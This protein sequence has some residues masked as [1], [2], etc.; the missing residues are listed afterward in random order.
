MQAAISR[1]MAHKAPLR[2]PRE[3]RQV[4]LR[5]SG[6]KF[7]FAARRRHRPGRVGLHAVSGAPDTSAGPVTGG[8][9]LPRACSEGSTRDD[10]QTYRT[11][12]AESL[13][14]ARSGA[15]QPFMSVWSASFLPRRHGEGVDDPRQD[16]KG[17]PFQSAR[18]RSRTAKRG[19]PVA[20]RASV[21]WPPASGPV[22]LVQG[23]SGVRASTYA[24][25]APGY[26]TNL[27]IR[28]Q[29]AMLV[30]TGPSGTRARIAFSRFGEI[31]SP[32]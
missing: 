20:G 14:R 7:A 15:T 2:P 6:N 19:R 26:R 10:M 22:L 13:V 21:V 29:V 17:E 4:S 24:N 28:P 27:R 5:F 3:D 23:A 32:G 12:G 18:G 11:K 31:S 16:S 8:E 1:P 30:L 9:A 25:G